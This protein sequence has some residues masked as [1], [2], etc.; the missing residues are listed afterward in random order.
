MLQENAPADP[1]EAVR[2]TIEAELGQPIDEL[3]SEFDETPLASASIGQ[4]HHARLC[5]GE[6]VVVK[7]QHEGIESKIRVDLEI[8]L[9]MAQLAEMHPEFKNYRPTATAA[10]F[11]RTLLRELDFGRE[12]RN[13]QQ[14]AATFRD[15]PRIHLPRSYPELST[16]RVLTMERLQG[17]KLAEADRLIA[18]GFDLREVARSGAELYVEMI[19]KH[20]VYHADPHPGNIVLLPG[21]VI[22]L[23][24]F[25]MVGRIDEQL[26][27]DIEDMLLALAN[28]DATQLTS[29]ITRVG[30]VP[31]DLDEAGLGLDINEFIEQYAARPID[32][33]NVSAALGEM[34]EIIR[35]YQ[36]T[37][38]PRVGLLI[39]VLVMLE[40]TSRLGT[41]ER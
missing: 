19:F 5:G 35:R 36:I 16:P 17:I 27:E 40:G 8:I 38:P 26:R 28:H 22:G 7:V 23:L 6:S 2:A 21:N 41:C 18:E 4:V 20:G 15:D 39:K 13:L 33:L 12:E 24:D 31:A 11:Q 10:E 34:T 14:F 37:L 1:P 9:G 25:G 3:F 30:D 32:E 29:I